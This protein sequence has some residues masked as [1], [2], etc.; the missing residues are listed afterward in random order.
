MVCL[1][2]FTEKA[3]EIQAKVPYQKIHS[4]QK[5]YLNNSAY[6][7]LAKTAKYTRMKFGHVYILGVAGGNTSDNASWDIFK[8]YASLGREFVRDI[9]VDI[10][11]CFK[12][13]FHDVTEYLD[14]PTI[15]THLP[16]PKGDLT[17]CHYTC[18]NPNRD[19]KN[20][21][22]GVGLTIGKYS[23]E[24]A[25][26]TYVRPFL[27]L[28]EPGITLALSSKAAYGNI[29]AELIIE[30]METYRYL[31]VDKIVTHYLRTINKNALHVLNYYASTGILD[32]YYHEPANSGSVYT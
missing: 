14:Q 27:P 28:R 19:M 20:I 23:C 30:W 26:V 15:N 22:D 3:N 6:T 32:L 9:H 12:Y 11:C 17:A 25:F 31:G 18:N 5:F 10:R 7:G 21:P 24:E 8:V 13:N 2:L 1:P 4:P 29:S 16:I